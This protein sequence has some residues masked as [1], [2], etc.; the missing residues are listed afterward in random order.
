MATVREKPKR[1]RRY[2][3]PLEVEVLREDDILTGGELLPE[4][5]VRVGELFE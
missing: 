4:F 5:K 3:A 1:K 2:T